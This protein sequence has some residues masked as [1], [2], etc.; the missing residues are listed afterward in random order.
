MTTFGTSQLH[1]LPYPHQQPHPFVTARVDQFTSR[2]QQIPPSTGS[3]RL[4]GRKTSKI[5]E[6]N[7]DRTVEINARLGN[8][9]NNAMTRASST[10]RRPVQTAGVVSTPYGRVKPLPVSNSVAKPFTIARNY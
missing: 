3:G 4:A 7:V 2:S 10:V 8:R 6:L 1:H 9:G 5:D